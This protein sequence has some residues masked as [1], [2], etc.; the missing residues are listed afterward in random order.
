MGWAATE[1]LSTGR[2]GSAL[3]ALLRSSHPEPTAA[4]TTVVTVLAAA[5]GAGWRVVPVFAAVASNQLSIGWDN[6]ALDAERDRRAG[7]TDKPVA[8]GAVRARTVRLAA[9][10]AAGACAVVSGA[11]GRRAAVANLT[12]VGAG[13]AYNHALKATAVSPLPY[14]VG[15]GALAAF[16]PLSLPGAPAPPRWLVLAGALLGCSAHFA[17]VVPDIADD[18]AAGVRGL[19]QALGARTSRVAFAVLLLAAGAVL[20]AGPGDDGHRGL[21]AAVVAGSVALVGPGLVVGGRAGS[22]RLFRLALAV[23]V[24]DVMLLVVRGAALS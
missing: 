3:G 11:L 15:F 2:R 16:V 7:R 13:W 24:L 9:V 10:A 12:C 20:A 19:P 18:L 17:N 1:Q 21:A 5:A 8:A 23:A 6:D 22:R 4:V 14:L